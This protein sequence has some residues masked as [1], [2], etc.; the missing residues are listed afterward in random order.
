MKYLLYLF[1]ALTVWTSPLQAQEVPRYLFLEH[2]TNTHCGLC[3][4][5]NPTLFTTLATVPGK[6]HH[7][8]V[9]PSVPYS[10]CALY[11]HNTTD[12]GA[13]QS[14]YGVQ[15]TPVTYLWGDAVYQGATLLPTAT[16]NDSLDQSAALRIIVDE[17]K[18]GAN[19][20]V[21]IRVK[22]YGD[23]PSGDV[24]LFV[25]L[26]ERTLNFSAP[27]GENTH[28][29]VFRKMLP[30]AAGES[31]GSLELGE[32]KVFS[33]S[34]S[35][36]SEWSADEIYALA[37]VQDVNSKVVINSGTSADLRV[38][39]SSV[40][41][42]SNPGSA[43]VIAT[44]GY[45]PYTYKWDDPGNQTTATATGLPAGLYT[46]T[47]TDSTGLSLKDTVSVAGPATNIEDLRLQRAF[48]VLPNP[49]NE[50]VNLIL[51]G[52]YAPFSQVKIYDLRG[53]IQWQGELPLSENA[54]TVDVRDWP[55]GLYHISL[56]NG[57]AHTTT[58]L[59]VQ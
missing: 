13:R 53:R 17:L 12:N 45:A 18:N 42:T 33:F 4:S 44:G 37:F 59:L 21:T 23:L 22:R 50:Q 26:A 54:Y 47:V 38:L 27:N 16:L 8:A 56:Q 24:R 1:A 58:K 3:A 14:Y 51:E 30:D 48:K 32:E 36:D 52:T 2:F 57:T 19:S 34:F 6:V 11:N 39:M 31:L 49:A 41:A 29:N 15:F 5:R 9:H 25:A 40:P 7:L 43:T 28:H 55:A 46:V 10:A 20:G 35:M